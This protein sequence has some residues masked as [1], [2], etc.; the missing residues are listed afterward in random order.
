[1]VFFGL[2]D[3]FSTPIGRNFRKYDRQNDIYCADIIN[4]PG[5]KGGCQKMFFLYLHD[6]VL[7]LCYVVCAPFITCCYSVAGEVVISTWTV[8]NE[9]IL[10][11]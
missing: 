9:Y 3:I 10:E 2:S 6:D 7:A 1:M 4:V 5:N 8:L 11:N